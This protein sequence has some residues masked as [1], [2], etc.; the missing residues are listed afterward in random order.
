MFKKIK[1]NFKVFKTLLA[2]DELNE[3]NR[4][5]K[6][7]GISFV[8]LAFLY[9]LGFVKL[10]TTILICISLSG[11]FFIIGDIFEYFCKVQHQKKAINIGIRYKKIGYFKLVKMVCQFS[12]IISLIIAPY[13][14]TN[15]TPMTLTKFGNTL[16]MIAIGLT[17][18]KIGLDN[19]MKK[20]EFEEMITDEFSRVANE[21]EAVVQD[22]K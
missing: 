11:I 15:L 1:N 21:Y 5:I 3:A 22:K 17:V 13:I 10:S 8:I 2:I 16:S 14:T 4:I 6:F 9:I 7:L 18:F 19:S 20:S 12:A